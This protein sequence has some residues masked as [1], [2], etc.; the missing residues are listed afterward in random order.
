M[1]DEKIERI[2]EIV[3]FVLHLMKNREV[4]SKTKLAKLLYLLDVVKSRQGIQNFTGI[5]Y[6]GIEYKSYYF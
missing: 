3:C 5:E 2:G 1:V 4:H 6:T